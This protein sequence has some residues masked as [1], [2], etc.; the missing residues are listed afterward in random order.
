MALGAGGQ[1]GASQST[2]G[3]QDPP[4]PTAPL[5]REG[6]CELKAMD[7]KQIREKLSAPPNLPEHGT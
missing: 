5:W 3:Q 1:G 2:E 4:A 6:Y 7:G